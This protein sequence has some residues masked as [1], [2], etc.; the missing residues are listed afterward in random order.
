MNRRARFLA[1]LPLLA[2]ACQA[3]APPPE[4]EAVPEAVVAAEPEALPAPIGTVRVTA[5]KLNVRSEPSAASAIVA[6]VK[7]GERLALLDRG[8]KGWYRV[9]VA[10]GSAGWIASQY[11]RE[12]KSC[13]PDRE[14]RIVDAPPLTFA[15]SGAHGAVI[16]EAT[17]G[18]DGKVVATKVIRNDT[19]DSSLSAAAEREIRL[20]RFEAPIRNCVAKRFIYTYR[21]TF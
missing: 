11:A 20:A 12:V 21:R 19:G 13:P 10:G 3:P 14:F 1:L 5:S 9:A 16:I 2:L 6:S 18:A 15:D 4:P 8:T 7:R 17:V